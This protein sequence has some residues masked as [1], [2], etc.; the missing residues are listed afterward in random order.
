MHTPTLSRPLTHS[1]SLHPPSHTPPCRYQHQ[2]A[3]EAF[4]SSLTNLSWLTMFNPHKYSSAI[5][6]RPA[7]EHPRPEYDYG[8]LI[9]M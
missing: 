4:N 2:S 9:G 6:Q 5:R 7:Q 8:T 1:L 3:A